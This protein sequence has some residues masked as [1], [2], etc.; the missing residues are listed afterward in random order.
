MKTARFFLSAFFVFLIL[1]WMQPLRA[2]QRTI[3]IPKGTKL[4]KLG[5]GHFK[6]ILPSKQIVELKD[7]N[8]RTGAVGS[9]QLVDPSPP[10]KPV[11][12]TQGTLLLKIV[13]RA[14]AAKLAAG[15]QVQIDDDITWLPL[16]LTFHLTGIIDPTPPSVPRNSSQQALPL[17]PASPG[18]SSAPLVPLPALPIRIDYI[19]MEPEWFM[20]GQESLYLRIEGT[21]TQAG[22]PLRDGTLFLSRDGRVI[23]RLDHISFRDDIGPI[24]IR[25]AFHGTAAPGTYQVELIFAGRSYRSRE[26][27]TETMTRYRF[28]R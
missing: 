28:L 2:E 18:I 8:T 6:F 16:S 1:A 7:W 26:F 4:A 25:T 5:P 12:G 21:R 23:M 3:V 19:M 14:D 10:H 24:N 27:R 20:E 22:G 13:S 9:I 15:D 17:A 11:A